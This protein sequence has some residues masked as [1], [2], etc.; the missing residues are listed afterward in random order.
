VGNDDLIFPV[1]AFL[2]TGAYYFLSAQ[3]IINNAFVHG[4]VRQMV[5]IM[6]LSDVSFNLITG[7]LSSS[8]SAS[9]RAKGE[10]PTPKAAS[11]APL[12]G[13][14]R[15]CLY[16]LPLFDCTALVLAFEAIRLAGSGFQQ[17]VGG[18][19]IPISCVLNVLIAG[20]RYSSG[21]VMGISLVMAGLA[22]KAKA[23]L[24]GDAE[25]P[26]VATSYVLGCNVCYGGEEG[27]ITPVQILTRLASPFL[28]WMG[29]SRLTPAHAPSP[30]IT[31]SSPSSTSSSSPAKTSGCQLLF[32]FQRPHSLS[33]VPRFARGV[34]R[35]SSARPHLST[36]TTHGFARAARRPRHATN[37]HDLHRCDLC[38]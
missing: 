9:R 35:F 12:Q 13:W 5:G 20:K 7:A 28:D 17:T 34:A 23:L 37:Y 11:P 4:D 19:A 36:R 2:L 38:A 21:Q 8:S 14:P 1:C 10:N 27:G 32:S 26:L 18:A 25:F 16:C 15:T 22:V 6:Y 31:P 33:H 24:D 29:R 30:L 3:E